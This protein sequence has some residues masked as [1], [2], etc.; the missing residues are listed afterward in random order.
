MTQEVLALGRL[1]GKD[2]KL[3]FSASDPLASTVRAQEF[4]G[5]SLLSLDHRGPTVL[6]SAGK[7]LLD[8]VLGLVAIVVTSPILLIAVLAIKRD[9]PHEPVIYKQVRVGL[10]GRRFLL[11]KL[12]TMVPK[13]EELRDKVVHLNEMVGG[14]VFKVRNDPRVTRPGRW[15]RRLSIDELPQLWNVLRGEMSLVG[16][17]PPLP[18]EVE[19]Y[20]DQF[21]RRLSVR[22]GIT[23]AW[24]VAGRNEVQFDEWMRLDLDYIDNWSLGRDLRIIAQTI[25]SVLTGR[26]AS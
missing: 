23:G 16:P 21:R 1:Y 19:Q 14:P 2:V 17:R 13:A 4:F 25:P 11:Y 20:P 8:V 24:Q 26:G 6:A 22:P 7:R 3:L 10:N 18:H 12:R 15:I 5:G 9:E